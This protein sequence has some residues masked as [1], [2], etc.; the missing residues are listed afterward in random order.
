MIELLT[1]AYRIHD[2]TIKTAHFKRA[3]NDLPKSF[4]NH[5]VFLRLRDDRNRL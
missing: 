1:S 3:Q 2:Q 4:L 5:P